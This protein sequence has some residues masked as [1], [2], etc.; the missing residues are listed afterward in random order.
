MAAPPLTQSWAE[1]ASAAAAEVTTDA[2]AE[3]RVA[4]RWAEGSPAEL[5]RA[6]GQLLEGRHSGSQYLLVLVRQRA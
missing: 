5:G 3:T 4:N 6:A 2:P 1:R